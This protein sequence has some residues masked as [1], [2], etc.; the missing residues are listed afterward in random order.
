MGKRRIVNKELDAAPGNYDTWTPSAP[1]RGP[2]STD[3]LSSLVHRCKGKRKQENLQ[4]HQPYSYQ[5]KISP[6]LPPGWPD[7][8]EGGGCAH[9]WTTFLLVAWYVLS[10]CRSTGCSPSEVSLETGREKMPRASSSSRTTDS[11]SRTVSTIVQRD[12]DLLP[13]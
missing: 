10:R 9:L 1:R 12:D 3:P 7:C 6:G 8:E 13:R 4:I 2:P 5:G 11:V